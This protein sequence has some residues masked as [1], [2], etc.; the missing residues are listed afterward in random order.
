MSFRQSIYTGDASPE[1]NVYGSLGRN[2]TAS[3][4]KNILA[5]KFAICSFVAKVFGK[6]ISKPF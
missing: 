5:A 4:S 6:V 2:Y 1:A 3:I